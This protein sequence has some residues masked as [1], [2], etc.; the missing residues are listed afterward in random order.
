MP[1]LPPPPPPPYHPRVA[2]FYRKDVCRLIYLHSGAEDMYSPYPEVFDV[3]G[4]LMRFFEGGM[5]E[6]GGMGWEGWDTKGVIK[7]RSDG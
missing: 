1:P 3:D 6:V 4:I 5:D 2:V 7:G